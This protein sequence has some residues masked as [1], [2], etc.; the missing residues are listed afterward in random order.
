MLRGFTEASETVQIFAYLP[1]GGPSEYDA[2]LRF[3]IE[4]CRDFGSLPTL[5][6]RRSLLSSEILEH[7]YLQVFYQVI[8]DLDS[9]ET[10][11]QDEI[12]ALE[13]Y[14]KQKPDHQR[15]LTVWMKGE[16][17]GAGFN[18]LVNLFRVAQTTS[19]LEIPA[20]RAGAGDG[21][22]PGARGKV[23]N[24]W[25]TAFP[26]CQ[27]YE[28]TLTIDSDGRIIPCPRHQGAA[29]L[30]DLGSLSTESL[31]AVLIKKGRQS[32]SLG[33][34][35]RCHNCRL[36]ARL[37]WPE[38]RGEFS[39]GLMATGVSGLEP[40]PESSFDWTL[41]MQRDISGLSEVDFERVLQ[42][43]AQRLREWSAGTEDETPA[44]SKLSVVSIETPVIKAGWLLPCIV[45]VLGQSSTRWHFSLLWD[46]GDERSRRILKILEHLRDPRISAYFGKGVGVARARKF[47][48]EKTNADYILPLDD[49]DLLS[50]EAVERF[51]EAAEAR[52]WSGIIRARRN[53][54]DDTGRLIDMQDWFPFEPRHYQQGMTRDL[55][56]HSQPYLISRRAY[57][58]TAGWEG[59]KEYRFAGED[60]DIFAKVEEVAEIEL[61]DMVLYSYRL[62]DRRTSHELGT[63]AAED[64]WKRLAL[65]ALERRGLPLTLNN[66][67]QPFSY[68]A[69]P[70]VPAENDDFDL[71]IA[72]PER[73]DEAIEQT[74]PREEWSTR[75]GVA[76]DAIHVVT[77][78]RD[79][80][81]SISDVLKHSDQKYICIVRGEPPKDCQQTIQELVR[82]LETHDADLIGP[83]AVDFQRRLLIADPY[84]DSE[85]MPA[86]AA[87]LQYDEGRF[88]YVMA[89]P[90]LPA[91]M[92]VIRRHVLR[93]IGGFDPDLAG[94]LQDADFCLRA[95]SRGF[96][97][98]YAGNVTAVG[99]FSPNADRPAED[100]LRFLDRWSRFPELLFPEQIIVQGV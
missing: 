6:V 67:K 100:K 35:D 17:N 30:P 57:N 56:N 76:V 10:L 66:S 22:G 44:D 55:Y 32:H 65:K 24:E 99:A 4:S 96:R 27:L 28:K 79:I 47:L 20:F 95:R 88:D 64:M 93:S 7:P 34:L 69:A 15:P 16:T 26:G 86:T 54:V 13:N 53:F 45:S 41:A 92:L 60:C 70:S 12:Q 36:K 83:K 14:S 77:Q 72:P 49:D 5:I 38:G 91:V 48:T 97:C 94:N 58:Q 98:C 50:P 78:D 11:D 39:L 31:E 52:P 89:A 18:G 74:D 3:L 23:P 42:E 2:L 37:L 46:K 85:L 81:K 90:W 8:V 84:F 9:N 51:L 43:F 71:L 40:S 61:L 1:D 21:D 80:S 29:Q 87:K 68:S 62:S 25:I 19:E 59:F 73:V 63:T 33:K 75:T 82:E